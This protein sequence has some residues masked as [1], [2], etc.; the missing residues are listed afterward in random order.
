[1]IVPLLLTMLAGR[2]L[3]ED[4]NLT[5]QTG[6]SS[7]GFGLVGRIVGVAAG[8]RNFAAGL[9]YFTFLTTGAL[10]GAEQYKNV[11][12][13]FGGGITGYGKRY[14]AAYANHASG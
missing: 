7:N 4:G 2:A 9:G 1:M 11:F 3:D 5:L 12:P 13:S 6:V 10:A 8:D 14:A